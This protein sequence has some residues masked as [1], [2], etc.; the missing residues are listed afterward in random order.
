MNSDEFDELISAGDPAMIVVTAAGSAGRA[1]CLVGFHSQCSI[2]PFRYAIWIST[3]NHTAHVAPTAEHL[4]LH[5]LSAPD[6]HLAELFGSV[7]GDDADKFERCSHT[8]RRN[9]VPELT[10]CANRMIVRR[11]ATLD[12]GGDHLCLTVE[13]IAVTHGPYDPLRLSMVA[14]ISAGHPA[15]GRETAASPDDPRGGHTRNGRPVA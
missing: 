1:G 10:D 13:P 15:S 7:S 2:S 3:A 14:D 9:G 11:V 4:G 8:Q 6:R 12:E 5:F